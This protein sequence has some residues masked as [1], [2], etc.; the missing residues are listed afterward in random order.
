MN[1]TGRYFERKYID[2]TYLF[3]YENLSTRT[4]LSPPPRSTTPCPGLAILKL[5][6][7]GNE[8][9]IKFEQH[10]HVW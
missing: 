6:T 5:I 9:V 1:Q 4:T 10:V 2:G 3:Q 7:I 8:M